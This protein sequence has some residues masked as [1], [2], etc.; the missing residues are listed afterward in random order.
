LNKVGKLQIIY[1][2]SKWFFF[3]CFSINFS[4]I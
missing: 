2:S 4:K 1:S 3:M